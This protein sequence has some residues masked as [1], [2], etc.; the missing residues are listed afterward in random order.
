MNTTIQQSLDRPVRAPS[1]PGVVDRAALRLGIALTQWAT[2]AGERRS[3]RVVRRAHR[4]ERAQQ[5]ARR[6]ARRH[7]EQTRIE[8]WLLFRTLQ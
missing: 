4:A 8:P 1:G 6:D 2:L 7:R 5:P 3:E